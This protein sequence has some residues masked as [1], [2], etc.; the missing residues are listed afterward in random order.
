MS[1]D[2]LAGLRWET[3]VERWDKIL[4]DPRPNSNTVFVSTGIDGL[5]TGFASI[6][7]VRDEDLKLQEFFE[8]YAIYVAPESWNL[9]FGNALLNAALVT[10]PRST[11]GLSLWVLTQNERGRRFYERAG[12]SADGTRHIENI[13]GRDLEEMRYII[14][15]SRFCAKD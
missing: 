4:R 11:P 13:G 3:R 9:G 15:G 2:F 14:P 12:F 7:E 1:K 6:G 5:V 10:V 8:L